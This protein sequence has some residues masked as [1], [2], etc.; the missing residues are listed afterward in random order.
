MELTGGIPMLI[1]NLVANALL[2]ALSLIPRF[3]LV[4]LSKLTFRDHQRAEY[5]ADN[6]AAHAAGAEGALGL[7]RK[8]SM[9]DTVQMAVEHFYLNNSKGE[10]FS[11][12]KAQIDHLPQ[13]ELDRLDQVGKLADSRLGPTD[14]PTRYRIDLVKVHGTKTPAVELSEVDN[15]TVDKEIAQVAPTY[16]AAVLEN[17]DKSE[18]MA[19]P[20]L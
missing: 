4:I 10:L 18:Y 16:E 1:A 5:L 12:L 9:G 8:L 7:L 2:L 14:P 17:L 13:R 20:T 3:W 6:L 11:A 15:A 19:S